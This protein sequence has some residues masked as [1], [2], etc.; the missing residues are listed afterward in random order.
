[1]LDRDRD[2]IEIVERV[3]GKREYIHYPAQYVF[4]YPDPAGEYKSLW[5]EPLAKVTCRSSKAFHR[6]KKLHSGKRLF[7]SDIN[8]VFRCIEDNYLNSDTAKLHL[9]FFDI[10]VAS[11]FYAYSNEHQVKIRKKNP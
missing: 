5:N 9:G 1:M 8:P 11:Q 2:M 10:E 6:E 7:E 4:Y 3:N